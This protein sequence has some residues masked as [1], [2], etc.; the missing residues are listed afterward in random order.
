MYFPLHQ[1]VYKL[2]MNLLVQWEF[3]NERERERE[4]ENR[5]GTERTNKLHS[6]ECL[7]MDFRDQCFLVYVSNGNGFWLNHVLIHTHTASNWW[8]RFYLTVDRKS[9]MLHGRNCECNA[10]IFAL[11]VRDRGKK[12]FEDVLNISEIRFSASST[13]SLSKIMELESVYM[14]NPRIVLRDEW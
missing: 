13:E 10:T 8:F 11:P 9:T 6:T 14:S 7:K 1:Y 2:F 4:K 12:R 5:R 3:G